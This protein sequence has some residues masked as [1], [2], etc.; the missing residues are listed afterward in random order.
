MSYTYFADIPAQ[1]ETPVDGT[2]SRTLLNDDRAKVVLFGFSAD[3][4]LSEHTSSTPAI[5]QF[6]SGSARVT[7]GKDAVLAQAGTWIHMP[8]RLPHSIHTETPVVMLLTLL[9]PA[10]A[11]ENIRTRTG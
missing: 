10:A 1:L 11:A 2:L 6:F 3:Q 7:L 9:K 5:L 8:A 4:E